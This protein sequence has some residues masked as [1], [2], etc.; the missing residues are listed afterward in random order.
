MISTYKVSPEQLLAEIEDLQRSRSSW[1]Q[2]NEPAALEWMGRAQAV[3]HQ[4]D[5]T[6]SVLFDSA[7]K[8]CGSGSWNI[9]R[10][11]LQQISTFLA[12]A[13]HDLLIRTSRSGTRAI[14]K[15]NVF[16]YFDELRQVIQRARSELFLLTAQRIGPT[17][18]LSNPHTTPICCNTSLPLRKK[19]S[20]TKPTASPGYCLSLIFAPASPL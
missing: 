2:P 1:L 6:Q 9:A 18:H 3:V 11:A 20:G 13:R 7:I 19:A 8:N 14:E 16:D 4:W 15:G 5:A 12:R 10:P 17:S